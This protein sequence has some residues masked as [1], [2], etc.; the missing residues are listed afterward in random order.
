L[1]RYGVPAKESFAWQ[2]SALDIFDL[3]RLHPKRS[4]TLFFDRTEGDLAAL[5]YAIDRVNVL[6]VARGA[7][8]EIHARRV[9]VPSSI[10]LRAVS[11]RIGES[12]TI[13]CSEAGVPERI[14]SELTDIF[15]W[16]VDFDELRPGDSFRAVYEV[17]LDEDGEVVQTGTI[18][19]A[20]VESGGRAFTAFYY[21]DADGHDAYF[22]GDG[23]SLDR[24]QLRYPL[25]FTRISSEFSFSR[26]HPIL[27]R[28]R[29]HMG[30]DFAA[31][32]G[33]PVRAVAD[34]VVSVAGWRGQLGRTVRIEH[35]AKSLA[36]LYGHLQRIAS[37]VS[38]GG[39]VAKGEVIGY[40]GQSGCAT[41]PHLHFAL[42]AGDDYLNPLDIPAPPRLEPAAAPGPSFERVKATLGKTLAALGNDGP[43]R[44]TRLTST[45]STNL[46]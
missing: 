36:S 40:V 41:G 1:K 24:G 27:R 14:V 23:R 29:P 7:D 15:A 10:E 8:G 6:V 42:F 17:A 44:L 43:I 26:F 20:E 5:E 39:R 3:S 34:G 2:R 9:L 35:E 32:S 16:D 22:D 4:L 33:T 21:A 13:D 11:G 37:T 25:E 30:V 45:P 38:E 31:P 28:D 46:E 19:A 18:L 12:M